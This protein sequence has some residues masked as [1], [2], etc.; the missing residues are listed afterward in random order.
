MNTCANATYKQD[1]RYNK[2]MYKYHVVYLY[3][4]SFQQVVRKEMI[5]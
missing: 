2:L 4:Y 5:A 1:D 3:L